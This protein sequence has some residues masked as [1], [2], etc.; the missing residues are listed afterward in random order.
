MRGR[1]TVLLVSFGTVISLLMYVYAGIHT[2]ADSVGM[3][4]KFPAGCHSGELLSYEVGNDAPLAFPF[5]NPSYEFHVVLQPESTNNAL[6]CFEDI[7]GK[8]W[9]STEHSVDVGAI[10][11]GE[12]KRV[13]FSLYPDKG[14]A[15]L[16]L[17]LYLS[18]LTFSL[19]VAASWC[20][21]EYQGNDTYVFGYPL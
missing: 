17:E 10:G 15:Y 7:N 19:R 4:G 20:Y 1:R 8:R 21:V 6:V 12:S 9:N 11:P 3:R 14:N 16:R 13:E 2:Y 5:I 18:F